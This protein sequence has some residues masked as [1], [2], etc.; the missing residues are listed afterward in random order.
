MVEHFRLMLLQALSTPVPAPAVVD[1]GLLT[2]VASFISQV[3]ING[4]VAFVIQKMKEA[5]TPALNWISTNTPGVT[6][7]VAAAAAAATAVGIHWTFTGQTLMITGLSATGIVTLLY[8]I[9]QNYLFQHAWFKTI[10][11]PKPVSVVAAPA[12]VGPQIVGK[13]GPAIPGGD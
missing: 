4:F 6:R 8:N 5:Q 7:V 3:K 12:L 9:T 11:A 1:T 13:G 10:F 2:L